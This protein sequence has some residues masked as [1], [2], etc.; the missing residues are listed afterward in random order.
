MTLTVRVIGS[1]GKIHKLGIDGAV[2]RIL[3]IES[4]CSTYVTGLTLRMDD[5]HFR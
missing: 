1:S 3:A 2:F 5:A 4:T